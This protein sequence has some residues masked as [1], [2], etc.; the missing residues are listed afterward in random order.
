MEVLR[1]QADAL[2]GPA[3]AKVAL[4]CRSVTSMLDGLMREAAGQ[5]AA[6]GDTTTV[7]GSPAQRELLDELT[8]FC[9]DS[10]A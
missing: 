5:I 3:W 6:L 4:V 1:R 2:P 10:A 9:S 8:W 7:G